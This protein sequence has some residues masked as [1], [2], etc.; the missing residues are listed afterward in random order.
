MIIKCSHGIVCLAE[1]YG[2]NGGIVL[3]H[4][5]SMD[6]CPDTATAANSIRAVD[7]PITSRGVGTATV[8]STHRAV[9]DGSVWWCR[10]CG[11]TRPFGEGIAA[12]TGECVPRRWSS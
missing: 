8:L 10:E 12:F 5:A 1:N 6:R 2:R 7:P 4:P 11:Q 9:R 3:L